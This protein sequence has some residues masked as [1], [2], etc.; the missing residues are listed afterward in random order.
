[1]HVVGGVA[2]SHEGCG[3]FGKVGCGVDAGGWNRDAV[4]V[5]ADTYMVDASDLDDAIE[6]IDE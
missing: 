6:V 2:A 5:G 4:E 3:D 1:M